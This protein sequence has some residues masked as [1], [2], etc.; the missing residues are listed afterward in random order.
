MRL[1]NWKNISRSLTEQIDRLRGAGKPYVT[2]RGGMLALNFDAM[3]V[4]SQ[5]AV[6]RPDELTI[7]YTRAM[8]SFLLLEPLPERIAMIGLGGG[9]MAKYCYRHLPLSQITVVEISPEVIAL[10]DEFYI[11]PDDARFCVLQQDGARWVRDSRWQP[12]VLIV[13]GFDAE[14]LPQELSSQSFYDD[15]YAALCDNGVLAVNLWG[16]YP[17]FELCLSR[18]RNSFSGRVLVVDSDD[19]VNKIVLAVKNSAYPPS[20]ALIRRHAREL[21]CSHPL[22]FQ[23]K[24]NRLIGALLAEKSGSDRKM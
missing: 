9:S 14:G 2:R 7:S 8:M 12:D 23:S 20:R 11:P 10:R 24:A 21:C 22:N 19:G 4:Q 6:D 17:H 13:D 15:C 1:K 5:M 18:L 16:G 3:S